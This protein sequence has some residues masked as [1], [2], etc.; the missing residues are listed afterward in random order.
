MAYDRYSIL[1]SLK[2][3]VK[4]MA[5]EVFYTDR[6]AETAA[7]YK[8]FI[9]IRL[10]TMNDNGAYGNTYA[11]LIIFVK[12]KA[13]EE[14]TKDMEDL[15][16]KVMSVLPI[17]NDLIYTDKPQL[18]GGQSDSDGYHYITVYFNIWIK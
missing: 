7:N 2:D 3:A 1:K 16:V 11:N 8:N 5:T 15:K 10:G 17:N 9:V 13:G 14:A 6:P 12:D 4:G 18:L